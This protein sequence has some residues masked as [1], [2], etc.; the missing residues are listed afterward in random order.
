MMVKYLYKCGYL[1]HDDHG[2]Y[3]RTD[4]NIVCAQDMALELMTILSGAKKALTTMVESMTTPAVGVWCAATVTA[5]APAVMA[6]TA[7]FPGDADDA[8][9]SEGVDRDSGVVVAPE[10]G[11]SWTDAGGFDQDEKCVVGG[12]QEKADRERPAGRGTKT[13]G[14]EMT[15]TEVPVSE[16]V[17]CPDPGRRWQYAGWAGRVLQVQ[18]CGG[19][20]GAT[21]MEA[22][23]GVDDTH[24][25]LGDADSN[26]MGLAAEVKSGAEMAD[27]ESRAVVALNDES[28]GIAADL[29][30]WREQHGWRDHCGDGFALQCFDRWPTAIHRKKCESKVLEIHN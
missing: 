1:Y 4:K 26:G 28:A 29:E 20:S 16:V 9:A 15:D 27:S 19:G 24:T 23:G 12:G 8:G 2:R 22:G 11:Q 14:A 7:N 21:T 25:S 18:D 13:T 30:A 6:G 5:A 3:A 17:P 10:S